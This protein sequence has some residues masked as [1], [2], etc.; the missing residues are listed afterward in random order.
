MKPRPCFY[1]IQN[2]AIKC[3]GVM[4]ECTAAT[5]GETEMVQVA[6]EVRRDKG[7]ELVN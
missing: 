1:F 3:S 4:E 7:N 6:A 2:V 5:T